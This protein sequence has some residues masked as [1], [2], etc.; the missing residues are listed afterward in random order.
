ME[1]GIKEYFELDM[2][3]AKSYSPLTLAYIGDAIYELIIR[4]V[5]VAQGNAPVNKL[6]KKSSSLVNAKTQAA[7]AIKIKDI[8]TDEEMTV[9]KRGRNAK[10]HTSAKNASITDY[11]MATGFEALAGYLYLNGQ[12][13]RLAELIKWG[14]ENDK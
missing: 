5:V 2:P 4:M 10:S 8:L 3:A 1:T 6:H 13:E 9:Y 7:I 12:I 11:R 14:I